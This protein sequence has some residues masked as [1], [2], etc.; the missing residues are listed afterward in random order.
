MIL[1]I[2]TAVVF[3]LVSAIFF[4]K[5]LSNG[6]QIKKLFSSIHKPL[7]YLLVLLEVVHLV[8]TLPL[9]KQRPI[10]LYIL[11]AVM[12]VC[13]IVTIITWYLMKDKLKALKWHKLF[14]LIMALLLI[15]HIAFCVTSLNEYQQEVAAISFSN[16]EISD[17]ADGVYIGECNVGYIYVK[18]EVT[19]SD[20][21]ISNIKLLEHRNE[22]GKSGEKVITKILS[23]QKTNV[24]AISGATNSSNVIKKAVENAL[25]K[26]IK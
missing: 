5:K 10:I 13:T 15:V 21:I 22:R 24:E 16:P 19:I 23:D 14:T 4:T 6:S 12:V 1:G 17:V 3:V 8:L 11:G 20:G 7:G 2:I 26:G 18:V 9:I 25:E